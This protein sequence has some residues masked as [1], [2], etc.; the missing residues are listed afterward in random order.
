MPLKLIRKRVAALLFGVAVSQAADAADDRLKA[1]A[2][3][4]KPALID[5]LRDMVLIESVLA[6][7]TA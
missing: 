7:S 5:T 6:M 3:Q 4:A 1:A 2:E